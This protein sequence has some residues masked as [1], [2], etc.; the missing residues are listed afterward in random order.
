MLDLTVAE[1]FLSEVHTDAHQL[2]SRLLA[3]SQQSA[4]PLW[5]GSS[6][7]RTSR[8]STTVTLQDL[9][10]LYYLLYPV[11]QSSRALSPSH[12]GGEG[13][14][15]RLRTLHTCQAC[16]GR[17]SGAPLYEDWLVEIGC[18]K[19][20]LQARVLHEANRLPVPRRYLEGRV[21]ARLIWYLESE[22]ALSCPRLC[23]RQFN[24]CELE[25][26][27]QTTVENVYRADGK[28]WRRGNG[29]GARALNDQGQGR[30]GPP[31]GGYRRRC[32][33]DGYFLKRRNPGGPGFGVCPR[34]ER[35]SAELSAEL[36]A[37]RVAYSLAHA[38]PLGHAHAG[39][40]GHEPSRTPDWRAHDQLAYA[41]ADYAEANHRADYGADHS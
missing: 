18:G 30:G 36:S 41:R 37:D 40:L 12:F 13:M 33:R 19:E 5:S 29:L 27:K 25:W 17:G 22:E 16:A 39:T 23:L 31:G 20:Y 7:A 34:R 1:S 35:L 26:G 14:R 6:C 15:R 4:H 32:D 11:H 10:L 2:W 28:Q 8:E 9:Y 24:N 21:V 3:S 38:G